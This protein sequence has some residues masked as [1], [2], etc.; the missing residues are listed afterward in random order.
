MSAITTSTGVGGVCER[1]FGR[2]VDVDAG[3]G[4]RHFS[5]RWQRRPRSGSDRAAVRVTIDTVVKVCLAGKWIV[6][7]AR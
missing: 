6:G 5:D 2:A 3:S 1:L 7:L 4:R